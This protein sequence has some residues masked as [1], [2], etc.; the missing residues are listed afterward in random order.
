[1]YYL[2]TCKQTNIA[3]LLDTAYVKYD[4]KWYE[5]DDTNCILLSKSQI[6]VSSTQTYFAIMLFA[7]FYRLLMLTYF[8]IKL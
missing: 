2:Q 5:C 8:S 3:Y 4:G 7:Y 6:V 1:M